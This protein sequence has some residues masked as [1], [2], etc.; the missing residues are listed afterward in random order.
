MRLLPNLSAAKKLAPPR[1]VLAG[2]NRL[3]WTVLG[4]ANLRLKRMLVLAVAGC[5]FPGPLFAQF[6][7]E[8]PIEGKAAF[9]TEK[10]Y[11]YEAGVVIK[12][13]G[14]CEN[15]MGTMPIPMDWPEQSVQMIK[16]NL[17]PQ[18]RVDYVKLSPTVTHMQVTAPSLGQGE[19][20][21]AV[22]T[23]EIRVKEQLAPEETGMYRIPSKLPR[24]LKI[25]LGKSP[26][27]EVNHSKVRKALKEALAELDERVEPDEITPWKQVETFYD[28]TREHVEYKDGNL[29][30]AVAA[31]NDGN[32]DCEELTSLFVA[33]CRTHKIPARTVWV[34]GHCYPEFYLEDEKGEGRWF[35]CQAAGDRHFGELLERPILQKGDNFHVPWSSKPLR[36]AAEHLEIKRAEAKPEVKFIRNMTEFRG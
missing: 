27:I 14:V 28:W 10:V 24:G 2:K 32:G 9:G 23:F 6:K 34:P 26:F 1:Q 20:A 11:H 30:G 18:V 17:S 12:A 36:Y 33:L 7:T 19:E 4:A 5:L 29:K 25:F 15:V 22:V 13:H 21:K 3:I 8:A 35:P 16:E 31:L